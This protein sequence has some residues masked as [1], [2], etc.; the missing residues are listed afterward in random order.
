[1][2]VLKEQFKEVM[3]G[4]NAEK[5]DYVALTDTNHNIKNETT[6]VVVKVEVIEAKNKNTSRVEE[7]EFDK[8]C[9]SSSRTDSLAKP[10]EWSCYQSTRLCDLYRELRRPLPWY[11]RR[12]KTLGTKTRVMHP[13]PIFP[14]AKT[15]VSSAALK[16]NA[17]ERI[18]NL[19]KHRPI[20]KTDKYD[21]QM[22]FS[23]KPL[24]LKYKP[25]LRIEQLAKPRFP[26]K[27]SS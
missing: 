23:V 4:I 11:I 8:H 24:A 15:G 26:Q 1:M 13:P 14:Q 22:C 12:T 10:L 7:I 27:D 25:S 9:S 20:S 3:C 18:K 21:E 17:T 16:Y 6:A 19:A 2:I 5:I